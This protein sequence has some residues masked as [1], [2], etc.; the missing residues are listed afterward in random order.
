MDTLNL[1]LNQ[2]LD[3]YNLDEYNLDVDYL[4]FSTNINDYKCLKE[5]ITLAK[6]YFSKNKAIL[7]KMEKISIPETKRKAKILFFDDKK[8]TKKGDNNE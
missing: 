5:I 4:D 2:K 1:N 8:N 3:K 7:E 6:K